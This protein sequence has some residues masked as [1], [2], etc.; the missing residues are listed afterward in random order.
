MLNSDTLKKG[1][2]ILIFLFVIS[3]DGRNIIYEVYKKHH[4]RMLFIAERILGKEHGEEAVHDVF[5]NIIE[6]NNN[7]EELGDKPSR[8]FVIIVRNHSLNLLKKEKL[9]LVS[10]EEN[11]NDD[12]IFQSSEDGPEDALLSGEAVDNLVSLIQRLTPA[13]R[14]V[15]EYR[16][17]Q[18]YSN[19]EIAGIL[20]ISQTAVSTRIDKAKNRLKKLIESDGI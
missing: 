17:I 12:Y 19:I 6:K 16:Y 2:F 14:Q 11:F 7:I 13:T 15:L 20:G 8:Y 18:G 4:K 1:V 9:E 3:D 10:I 5:A